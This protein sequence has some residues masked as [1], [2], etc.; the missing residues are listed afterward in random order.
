[1]SVW[2]EVVKKLVDFYAIEEMEKKAKE[3]FTNV[4]GIEPEVIVVERDCIVAV[5]ERRLDEIDGDKL[6]N[7]LGFHHDE[8]YLILKVIVNRFPT[9]ISEKEEKHIEVN[10]R[11][12]YKSEFVDR[13][14]S[15]Y[16]DEFTTAIIILNRHSFFDED[17]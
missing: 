9:E 14:F 16:L 6:R 4:F 13:L 3:A 7:F 10:G 15:T 1:M 17:C 12:F 5:A 8:G 2:E 11:K